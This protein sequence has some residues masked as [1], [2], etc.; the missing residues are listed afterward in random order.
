MS[1]PPIARVGFGRGAGW[2]LDGFRLLRKNPLILIVLNMLALLL[3]LALSMIPVVG[4]YLLYL[5]TPI[6]LG[7]M[8]VA[9]RDLAAGEEIEI[10]HLFAG[11]RQAASQLIT[12]G[13]VYLVG[14][15]LV[16]GVAMTLGGEALREVMQAA[17]SGSPDDISPEAANEAASAVLVA[18]VLY[19]PVVM[20]MWFA[21]A[22][23][24]LDEVPAWQAMLL[25][26]KACLVNVLPFLLLSLIMSVLLT[27]ALMLF[28][29]GIALWVP[30]VMV[31]TYASYVDV[32]RP[33]APA[34]G[35]G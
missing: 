11:F 10:A 27:I 32:F 21:P 9:C 12:V 23:V 20:L 1:A 13:G 28:V 5:A 7:G 14:N 25:S 15:V 6:L 17:A 3:A 4:S 31:S 26:L 22:L 30:L 35:P 29:V 33:R 19:V 16:A 34:A 24:V 2:V 8:M 18:A